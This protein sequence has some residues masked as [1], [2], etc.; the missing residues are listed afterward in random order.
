MDC[1]VYTC[2][3]ALALANRLQSVAVTNLLT[4]RYCIAM[5]VFEIT[6]EEYNSARI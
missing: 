1:G 2:I 6:P 3:Y 4:A 5:M